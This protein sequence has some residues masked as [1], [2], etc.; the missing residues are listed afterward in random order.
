MLSTKTRE[1]TTPVPFLDLKG[2]FGQ[3]EDDL[4]CTL[5]EVARSGQYVL[6]PHVEAFEQMFAEY[7][8]AQ[9][10]VAVNS[11]TSALHLALLAAGVGPGDEV[12]TVP[13]TF[14]ATSWAISYVGARPVF[15]DIDPMTYTMDV[16][17]AER[18][19]TPKVRA[20][21]PVHLYGQPADIRGLVQLSRR[22]GIP[23]IE[24]AAQA[25]GATYAGKHVGNF[26]LCGCFSF[27]PGKNLGAYGEGGAVVTDDEKVAKRMRCLRDHAQAQRYVHREIG[28]NYRMDAFQGAI[29]N[30]KLRHLPRWTAARALLAARYHTLLSKLPLTLPSEVAERKHAWHLYVTMVRDRDRV[31]SELDARGI[32]TG[33]HYPIPLHMQQAYSHLGYV[34]GDFQVAERVGREC[35]SLPLFPEMTRQQQDAVCDAL[36][37]ILQDGKQP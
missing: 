18:L 19:I 8:G 3:L 5:L 37:D 26:G 29:L 4:S 34:P 31:R 36:K 13:M 6:G 25:H 21:L 11:G 2:Q 30:V 17:R 27:Y 15:V 35:L 33:L 14:I 32:Q 7:V 9:Y 1:M 22:H 24:D 28:F 20:I 16:E 12:L 10:C 23:L